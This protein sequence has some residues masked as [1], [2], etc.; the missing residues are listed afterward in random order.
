MILATEL[1]FDAM[2]LRISMSFFEALSFS[3]ALLSI[4]LSIAV[5][6]SSGINISSASV[7]M[8]GYSS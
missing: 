1:F 6:T 7:C 3:C 8:F 2:S 4:I 5:H